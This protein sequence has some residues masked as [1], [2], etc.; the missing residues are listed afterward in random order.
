[1]TISDKAFKEAAKTLNV[2]EALIRAFA[3]VESGRLGG[4]SRP[5]QPVVLFEGHWFYKYTDGKFKDSHPTLCYQR[6]TK[7]HYASN[8]QDE[9]NRFQTACK[10]DLKAALLSA[11]YG[12]F[13]VMGFNHKICGY[14]DV[15][16]F[17]E[18]MTESEDNHLKAFCGFIKN[19]NMVSLMQKFD[20]KALARKYNGEGY[21]LNKYDIKIEKAYNKFKAL[22]YS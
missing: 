12:R 20:Y 14:S 15:G 22:G 13:Q 2:S 8:Q 21:A 10:L 5:G 7:V 6:W 9:W 3:E 19:N 16:D 1:M 4:F 17:V 18:A 11:S